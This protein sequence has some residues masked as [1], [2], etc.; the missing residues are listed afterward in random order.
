MKKGLSRLLIALILITSIPFA[1]VHAEVTSDLIISEYIEGGGNDNKAVEIF[2]GTGSSVDLSQYKIKI[3]WFTS[4]EVKKP[5]YIALANSETLLAHGDVFVVSKTNGIDPYKIHTDLPSSS[6]SKVNGDDTVSLVKVVDGNDVVIDEIGDIGKPILKDKTFVRKLDVTTGKTG[7]QNPS[8]NGEWI[9]HAKDYLDDLGKHGNIEETKCKPV[10]S[11]LA[12]GLVQAGTELILTTDTDGAKIEV[13][14]HN[15]SDYEAYVDFEILKVDGKFIINEDLT[16]RVRATKDGLEASDET[17]LD[18]Q[19]TTDKV[20]STVA[21]ARN[22]HT[23]DSTP[24][25]IK[26]IVTGQAGKY[27]YG[28][29]NTAGIGIKVPDDVSLEAGKEV[30]LKGVLKEDYGFCYIEIA[31]TEDVKINDGSH[32]VVPTKHSG[33]LNESLEGKFITLEN[34]EMGNISYGKFTFADNSEVYPAETSWLTKGLTYDYITGYVHYEYGNYV[35]YVEDESFIIEDKTRV[36]KIKTNAKFNYFERNDKVELTTSTED[37]KIYYTL[38]GSE[39]TS[40][41][42]LYTAPFEVTEDVTIKAVATHDTLNNSVIKT[43]DLKVI[44]SVGDKTIQEIQGQGHIS[45]FEEKAVTNVTGIV[46]KRLSYKFDSYGETIKGFYMQT[47]SDNDETT[48]D[49]IFVLTD[50]YVKPGNS[51][52]VNGA[53]FE[54][55]KK[56]TLHAYD[57]SNQLSVTSI[58]A[59]KIS[60]DNKENALPTPIVLGQG[61]RIVPHDQVSSEDFSTYDPTTFAIDFYESLEGMYVTVNNPVVVGPYVN[62]VITVVPD[63]LAVAIKDGDVNSHNGL[64]L[65]END[66]NNEKIILNSAGDYGALKNAKRFVMGDKLEAPVFGVIDYE[67]AA[68]NIYLS[69]DV[70]APEEQGTVSDVFKYETST[71]ELTIAS[72][73]VYNHGGKDSS[74]KTE[75]IADQI[76]N[77]MKSPDIIGLVE[78]QDNDSHEG[79]EGST[80]VDASE[81]YSKFIQAILD[82]GGPRYE[83]TDINPVLHTEGGQPGGNI[84]VGFLYN[85][86]RVTL[87][88]GTKGG[89]TE[90]V[91][92]DADGH[93]AKNPGRIAATDPAFDGTRKSLAAEFE[94]NGQSIIVIANHLKSKGGDESI[95]GNKQLPELHS[96]EKRTAQAQLVNDFVDSIVAANSDA[97]VVVLGD[98]NDFH[99]SAPVKALAG[100]VLNNMI[101]ELHKSEQFTYMYGGNAQVL[102]HILVTDN[103]LDD[104]RVDV[105]NINSTLSKD[106]RHS[107]HDPVMVAIA[108]FAPEGFVEPVTS[109]HSDDTFIGQTLELSTLTDGATIYYSLGDLDLDTITNNEEYTAPIPVTDSMTIQAVAKKGDSLSEVKTYTITAK[110]APVEASAIGSVD[111]DSKVTLTS[112][113][114]GVKIYYTKGDTLD[115]VTLTNNTEYTE[116][117]TIS[118]NMTIKTVAVLSDKVSDVNTYNYVVKSDDPITVAQARA[119][120]PNKDVILDVVVTTTIGG[121][122]NQSFYFQDDTGGGYIHLK[123]DDFDTNIVKGTHLKIT[124]K[125]EDRNGQF[126]IKESNLEILDSVPMPEPKVITHSLINDSTESQ[127]VKLVGYRIGKITSDNFDN[128]YIEAVKDNNLLKIKV[129]SR[130]GKTYDDAKAKLKV[131]D[132]IDVVGNLS[133]YN[134]SYR[135]NPDSLD[136]ITVQSQGHQLTALQT[137]TLSYQAKQTFSQ[138]EFVNVTVE[139][140]SDLNEITGT[141]LFKVTRN[142]RPVRLG[143][144]SFVKSNNDKAG[145]GFDTSGLESGTYKV[146]AYYWTSLVNPTVLSPEKSIEIVIE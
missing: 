120:D 65:T 102:D 85:P 110:V 134:G 69:K 52:T 96:A 128:T 132:I 58:E 6:M 67:W 112:E 59:W 105:I 124:G 145:F 78:V 89:S 66:S 62:R 106:V 104:T 92:V 10:S 137:T 143:F 42:Q 18:F 16:I 8:E 140:S 100:D 121:Y 17:V 118:E 116:A 122:G 129:D 5:I 39:P 90:T 80:V 88:D 44:D 2:N 61:G 7:V 4:G 64:L 131:D 115:L 84:R 130:S 43:I 133:E 91:T 28:E 93:L 99:Y 127:L 117:I 22:N 13:A 87:K 38:N 1:P 51:V 126:Q 68:Y 79:E 46:T 20:F 45:P 3:G 36:N 97:K 119:L 11:N 144:S 146:T 82:K 63:D 70:T 72:Y 55:I 32:E 138:N 47:T 53:V 30:E 31:A 27:I 123:D 21:D 34:A 9:V 141:V 37:A 103:M 41:S 94:F 109:N 25:D 107:D 98:M 75:G 74:K 71:N 125:T 48:S 56:N 50:E 23:G 15:G 12:T 108:G 57:E 81:T 19:V 26:V 101:N 95:Y 77:S 142:D 113:T 111:K 114:P 60:N 73:N 76:V 136:N 24:V 135:L 14:T 54:N 49:G 35:V 40:S 139:T 86:A 83:W 33:A 29:D